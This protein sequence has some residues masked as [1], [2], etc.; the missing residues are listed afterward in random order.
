MR[1]RHPDFWTTRRERGSYWF[2]FTGQN[3]FYAIVNSYLVTYTMMIGVDVAKTATVM[4]AV[5]LW[6]AVNDA[7]FGLIFDKVKFKKGKCLPWLRI[8][9]ALLPIS[10]VLLFVI[11]RSAGET[12]K[13][14]W[15]AVAYI[16]WDTAYTVCDVPI[17]SL[18]TTMTGNLSERNTLMSFGRVFSGLG[19]GIAMVLCTVL[20]SET[21]GVSFGFIA[22]IISTLGIITMLPLNFWGRERGNTGIEEE[23]FTLREMFRYLGKNKYLL[24]FYGSYV[25]WGSTATSSSLG[26]LVSYYL[27]GN[28]MFNLLPT[29]L[30]SIPALIIALFIPK[31]LERVDK[32]KLYISCI[33]A[34]VIFGFIIFAVGYENVTAFI[35]LIV[36]RAIPLSA[37][38]V[39]A[40]M[41]TPD[42][43]EY[44]KYKTGRDAKGITF[45]IQTFSSKVGLAVSSSLAM[46]IVGWFGWQTVNANSFEELERLNVVQPDTAIE[47]LWITYILVPAIGLLLS[48]IPLAFYKLRDK[49]VRIMAKCNFG[50]ITREEA[51]AQ[52]S[53]KY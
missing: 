8:S 1:N 10:T 47:G 51:E 32:F 43:A 20:A 22:V 28:S 42:C 48:L 44:G 46:I 38:G 25:I 19:G 12:V 26:M 35:I 21:V 50:E 37:T 16:L 4:F 29:V 11:P 15:F 36:L 33:A 17:Y 52:L 30:G 31:I 41:F 13:L 3:L 40:F 7:L 5:K 34:Q 49:D 27:F 9:T 53:R 14:A 45:A 23:T 6:D 2:F 39:M 24:L 18:V